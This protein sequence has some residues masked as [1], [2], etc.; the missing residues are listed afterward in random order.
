MKTTEDTYEDNQ[1][2]V[3]GKLEKG[4]KKKRQKYEKI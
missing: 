1:R 3:F 2:K 4:I